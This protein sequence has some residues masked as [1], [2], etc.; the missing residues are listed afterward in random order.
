MTGRRAD[1]RTGGFF[2]VVLL[3]TACQAS[4][5]RP[6]FGPL[7]GAATGEV[8]LGPAEATKTLAEALTADSIQLKF[9][10]E[11]DGVIVSEWLD[12]PGYQRASGRALGPGT[13]RVRAWV[14]LGVVSQGDTASVYTV[15]TAYRVYAD[16]SRDER[17]LEQP[18]AD[19]HPVRVKVVRLLDRLVK[20][21]GGVSAVADSTRPPMPP[22]PPPPPSA[23]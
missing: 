21:Y 11:S 17:E 18:V 4:T 23:R 1:G 3:L 10:H 2:L 7:P 22:P 16:P 13:V 6:T 15:E 12:V 5:T 20:Q 14:D 19:T 9:V 8:H